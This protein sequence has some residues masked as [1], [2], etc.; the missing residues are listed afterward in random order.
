MD[1]K[2]KQ[3]WISALKSGKFKQGRGKLRYGNQNGTYH[4]CLG[5]LSEIAVKE[6]VCSKKSAFG[7]DNLVLSTDVRLWAGLKENNPWLGNHLAAEWN[8]GGGGVKK[9]SF[10][11]IANKIQKYL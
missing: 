4:C 2:I 5:V 8:D 11:E 6:G 10:E 3:K 9:S 1:K 7:E